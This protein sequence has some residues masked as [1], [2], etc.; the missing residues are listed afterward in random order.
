M[1][2][3]NIFST[4]LEWVNLLVPL[5]LFLVVLIEL[6]TDVRLLEFLSEK[7]TIVLG[8]IIFLNA[9][10]VGFTAY[11]LFASPGLKPWIDSQGGAS[12][13]WSKTILFLASTTAIFLL[14]S[15]LAPLRTWALVLLLIGF[16][17]YSYHHAL[18]QSYGISIGYK[19]QL[20][21]QLDLS[22]NLNN[23]AQQKRERII[24]QTFLGMIILSWLALEL[25]KNFGGETAKNHIGD[26]VLMATAVQ[27]LMA[28]IYTAT[29]LFSSG[30]EKKKRAAFSVR[31]F[32]WALSLLS[33][34][35]GFS[36]ILVHG[37]EYL[38]ASLSLSKNPTRAGSFYGCAFILFVILLYCCRIVIGREFT[39]INDTSPFIVFG[40]CL[41]AGITI[42]HFYLDRKIFRMRVAANQKFIYP[43]LFGKIS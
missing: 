7:E 5:V 19:R 27:T 24:F 14:F 10:H 9:T 31:Y 35:A 18:S 16:R 36:T 15:Y 40:A 42:T 22:E 17:L 13:F 34:L 6:M 21:E 3:N 8:D 20:P 28:V 32:F 37:I 30:A 12:R 4:R 41:S 11:Y 25:L 29:I 39:Q 33:P 1:S 26:F 23:G 2:Q 43:L 38:M